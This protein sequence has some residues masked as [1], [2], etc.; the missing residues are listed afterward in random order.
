MATTGAPARYVELPNGAGAA[1]FLAAGIG[2]AALGALTFLAGAFGGLKGLLNIYNPAG[3]LSGVTTLAIVI[4]LAAWFVLARKWEGRDLALTRI[5]ITSF[6][7]LA[8][9]FALT[10]PP[11]AALMLGK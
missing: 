9:G 2:C 5:G 8:I 7:L 10:F 6:A 3:P 1:A 11:V 4:W